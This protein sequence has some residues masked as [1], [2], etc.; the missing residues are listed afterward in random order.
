MAF[1][2]FWVRPGDLAITLIFPAE[3][4]GP[5]AVALEVAEGDLEV[6]GAAAWSLNAAQGR[7]VVALEALLIAF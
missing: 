7:L 5:L 1:G 3:A 6:L 2:G 4:V